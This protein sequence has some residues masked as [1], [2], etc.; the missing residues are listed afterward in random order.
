[1]IVAFYIAQSCETRHLAPFSALDRSTRHDIAHIWYYLGLLIIIFLSV[2]VPIAKKSIKRSRGRTQGSRDSASFF[3]INELFDIR[4]NNG[5]S[6][7]ARFSIRITHKAN[8][9]ETDL[10]LVFTATIAFWSS[11][12]FNR[13][14]HFLNRGIYTRVHSLYQHDKLS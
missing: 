3:S 2:H 1:M 14:W 8:K 13:W 12:A 6:I 5:L 10:Y 11:W 4:L 9:N 7:D